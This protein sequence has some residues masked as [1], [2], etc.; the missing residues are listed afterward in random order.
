ITGNKRKSETDENELRGNK[1]NRIRPEWVDAA[2]APP[3]IEKSQVKLGLPK[4]K[5]VLQM[6]ARANDPTVVMECHNAPTQ[7]NQSTLVKTKVVTSRLGTILWVDYLPSAVLLMTGNQYF[8]AVSCEDG[9][10]HIYSPSGRRMLSPIMLESTPVMLQCSSQWLLC[11]TAT[12]LLYTWD[13]LNFKSSLDGVSIGPLL[14]IAALDSDTLH[15]APRIQD[16]RIQKNGLPILI[17]SLQQAFLYHCD[18][19]VWLRISDAW[20]IISEFWGSGIRSSSNPITDDT[21][22]NPLGWLSSRMSINNTV[23]PTTKLIMDLA[24]TDE[25]TTAAITISHIE[26]Q[27]AVAALLESPQEYTDWLMYYAKKLSEENAKEKVEE[28]CRWLLGPPYT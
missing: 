7:H 23:D 10:L 6:K 12:G 18:M 22:E 13:V 11:L 9:T 21:T 2:V 17:T 28:L 20:Y 26:T 14:Q 8:S 25:A 27:L 16:I 1:L 19:K 3:M 4:V 5:S 15:K 24:K